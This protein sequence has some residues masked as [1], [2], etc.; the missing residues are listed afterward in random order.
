[1]YV[2]KS[3]SNEHDALEEKHM[4]QRRQQRIERQFDRVDGDQK[5]TFGRRVNVIQSSCTY[6]AASS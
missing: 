2:A 5:T 1:M 6:V 4:E 3:S